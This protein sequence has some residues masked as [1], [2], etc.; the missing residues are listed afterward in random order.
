MQDHISKERSV[1]YRN[2]GVASV[3]LGVGGGE[4]GVDEHEGADD[5]GGEPRA[6]GVP[7][8]DLIGAAAVA[9]VEPALEAL[10]ERD[11]AD[12]AEALR[13]HVQQSAHQGDLARQEEA[14]RDG[15][16]DVA[17]RD[18][19]GA[20]DEDEDHAAERPRDA[21]DAHAAA[22]RVGPRRRRV[23]LVLVPDHRGHRDV[24]EQQRGHELGDHGAVQGPLP[25]LVDVDQR[26]RRRV[27]V[28]TVTNAA[29]LQSGHIH[30]LAHLTCFTSF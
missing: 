30:L 19:G 13:G 25:E 7:G 27:R 24:Q 22:R 29:G 12:G 23:R 5:L 10:D 6:G 9:R 15:R 4:D 26:C 18:A 14:E 16:V 11:A 1:C 8:A 28:V 20:V 3:A 17:A 21:Q 2:V